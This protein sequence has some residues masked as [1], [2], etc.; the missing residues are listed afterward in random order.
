MPYSTSA[1]PAAAT[2]PSKEDLHRI[3]QESLAGHKSSHVEG[4]VARIAML[5]RDVAHWSE[6]YEVAQARYEALKERVE[7]REGSKVELH[8]VCAEQR[9][10]IKEYER[11]VQRLEAKRIGTEGLLTKEL[12]AGA[13]AERLIIIEIRH[14]R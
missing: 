12:W 9:R 5:E 11:E 4:I 8:V 14:W 7:V 3:V 6:M 1:V 13:R 10:T 2:G